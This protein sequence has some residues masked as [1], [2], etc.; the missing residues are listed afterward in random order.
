ME[1]AAADAAALTLAAEARAAERI[2]RAELKAAALQAGMVDL[3]GLK[4]AD[5][6]QVKLLEDGAIEGA[7]ALMEALRSAKP[8]LFGVVSHSAA[9]QPAPRPKEAEAL[10]ARR[11]TDVE[12]K[13]ARER[14][15][16]R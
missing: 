14:L 8:W 12:Y 15:A 7:A 1:K 6:S 16:G 4:L 10:D 13:A 11:M 9:P 2:L 3:D 5:L